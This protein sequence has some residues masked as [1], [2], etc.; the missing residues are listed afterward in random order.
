MIL[1]F[2]KGFFL[3]DILAMDSNFILYLCIGVWIWNYIALA[4]PAY[5]DALFNNHLLLNININAHDILT[6]LYLRLLITFMMNLLV[7]LCFLLFFDVLFNVLAFI[8]SCLIL[9]ILVQQ[10]GK[11]LSIISF[12]FRDLTQLINSM[13]IV[14][15]FLSPI[16][17]YPQQ[18]SSTKVFLL[19]FNPIFHIL[20][21]FR[22]AIILG[23]Y[24]Q[25]SFIVCLSLVIFFY[26]VNYFFV[27][28]K[29]SYCANQ[30]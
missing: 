15:F 20:N 4:V 21:I 26:L 14:L 17:W 29:I 2:A 9:I 25:F 3:A 24:N 27:N 5:G 12:Y 30:I 22:D 1:V 6:I 10:I 16:F 18:I 23:S 19:Q 7:L 13:M 28:K 11:I 8:S